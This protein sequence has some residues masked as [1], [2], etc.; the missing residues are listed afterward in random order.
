MDEV[1]RHSQP[2]FG[3]AENRAGRYIDVVE[4][5]PWMVGRHVEGPQVLFNLETVGPRR[6]DKTGDAL[7]PAVAPASARENEIMR[8]DMQSGVPDL[9]PVDPPA[10]AL[11]L[12][13]RLHPGRVRSVIRLG[14]AER[15]AD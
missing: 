15:H 10:V 13:A 3:I 8:R 2:V 6:N 1:L 9:L 11:A 5:D 4:R 12:A 14:Q 7:G